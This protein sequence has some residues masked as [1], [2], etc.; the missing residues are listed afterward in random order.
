MYH[1]KSNT[2]EK[3]LY[4][5]SMKFWKIFGNTSQR[6]ICNFG[7]YFSHNKDKEKNSEK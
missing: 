5:I 3:L 2:M 7:K 4:I 6:Y 1:L